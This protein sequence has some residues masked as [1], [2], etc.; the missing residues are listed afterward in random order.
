MEISK[1]YI[2]I[3]V[4]SIYTH[5]YIYLNIYIIYINKYKINDEATTPHVTAIIL[6]LIKQQQQNKGN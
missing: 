2:C 5:I 4:Y 6:K 1:H 3:Y